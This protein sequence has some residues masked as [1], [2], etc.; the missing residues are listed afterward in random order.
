MADG[1]IRMIFAGQ[2]YAQLQTWMAAY[3]QALTDIAN[4]GQ[5]YS[6]TGRTFSAADLPEIRQT[7]GEIQA[8]MNGTRVR[9]TFAYGGGFTR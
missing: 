7:I 3:Q 4:T 2:P 6:V 9:R 8:A 5:H 1:N